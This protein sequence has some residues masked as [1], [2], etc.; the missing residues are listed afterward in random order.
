MAGAPG[1]VTL[2]GMALLDPLLPF[3]PFLD[4]VL[5][6][7]TVRATRALKD[8]VGDPPL[9]HEHARARERVLEDVIA[10]RGAEISAL[11]PAVRRRDGHA[12]QRFDAAIA[13]VLAELRGEAEERLAGT[14]FERIAHAIDRVVYANTPEWLDDPAFDRELRVRTLDR[15]DR[16]NEALGNYDAFFGAI[17]PAIA[18][19]WA[20]GVKQPTI[21]DLAS[22][23]AMF[24]VALAL[25]FGARE[26]RVR[27]V[28]TDLAP[29]YL[30]IGRARAR[31]LSIG[32]DALSFMPHDALDLRD[33]GDK[34]GGS[35][36]VVTCTQTLH[37]FPP[38]MVARL[39]AEASSV[40]RHGAVLVDAE[41]NPIALLTVTGVA[42]ALGRGS[43]P[44]LHD[45]FVSIRRMFTEQ[46]LAL[47]G[48]LAPQGDG[49]PTRKIE[50]GWLAP[51]HVFIRTTA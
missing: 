15:L 20:A 18:R 2:F 1:A 49:E 37:H 36:D 41:R 50:R 32:E 44:F 3:A 16:L 13:D 29:E 24:A 10:R 21:V 17:E 25:R 27:V 11:G 40:A 23:H 38:G 51:G 39:F 45:S 46:E 14:R 48:M 34:V 19:A 35:I 28:A 33:L 4:P 47:V 9:R 5:D 43:V 7:L 8:W 42:G 22:G 6:P 12:I 31:S 30:E 26:G